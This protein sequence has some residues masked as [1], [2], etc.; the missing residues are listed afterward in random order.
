MKYFISWVTKNFW[1]L[2]SQ[3]VVEAAGISRVKR[4]WVN[5]WA[6]R[7]LSSR[8]W[9]GMY[10]CTPSPGLWV[11][12]GCTGKALQRD[13]TPTRWQNSISYWCC[14]TPGDGLQGPSLAKSSLCG[15][16]HSKLEHKPNKPWRDWM[17]WERDKELHVLLVNLPADTTETWQIHK[18]LKVKEELKTVSL[19]FRQGCVSPNFSALQ[20]FVPGPLIHILRLSL[21]QGRTTAFSKGWFS[22]SLS[23]TCSVIS[24]L[25]SGVPAHRE[26]LDN[27]P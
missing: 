26:S 15:M 2:L 4:Y 21:E 14:R 6:R 18:G 19:N 7:P 25:N 8:E 22:T 9:W 20:K 16:R 24:D 11:L 1:V 23:G 3:Q 27:C 10:H 13:K 12:V 17:R 5:L